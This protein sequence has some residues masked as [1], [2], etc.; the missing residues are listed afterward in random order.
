[1]LGIVEPLRPVRNEGPGADLGE[2]VGERIEIAIGAVGERHLGREPVGGDAALVAHDEA[3]E[4]R[5]EF[6]VARRRNLAVVGDLAHPPQKRDGGAPGCHVADPFVAG[7]ILERDHVVDHARAGEPRMVGRLAQAIL[8]A[9]ERAEIELAVPPLQHADRIEGM[10]LQP[11]DLVRVEGRDLARH[12][13]CA[14]IHVAAR[15]AGDLAELGRVKIAVALAVE[16]ADAG[17][18]H[19][20]EVEIET[21]A[22]RVGRHQEI[23]VAVLVERDLRVARPRAERAEHDGCATALAPH[24]LGDGVDVVRREGDDGR[25]AGEAGDLL[26]AG[27]SERRQPRARHE[28]GAGQ[29]LADGVAHCGGAKQKRLGEPARVEQPVGEHVPAFAIG[30]ELDLVD[31]DEIGVEIERHRL[32]SADIEARARRLDL[33]LAGDERDLCRTDAG[34]DL[35]VDLAGE[36]PERQPDDAHVVREHALDGEMS[37][38]GI[39]RPQHGSDAAP[40]LRACGMSG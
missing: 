35:V 26:V 20:I 3:V 27:I 5:R 4:R 19:M 34:D 9:I 22:D 36:K 7:H 11:V 2:T 13:E 30:G 23:D 15:A 40:A 39:G 12:P 1:M 29:E 18:G 31:G 37:L 17:K 21:H 24:Q 16:F 28:I 38:A 6:G 10:V 32:D 25:A 14:V 33:L 8:E